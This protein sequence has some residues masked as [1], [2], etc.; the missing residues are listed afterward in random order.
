M[1]S[2]CFRSHGACNDNGRI[3]I[4]RTE[5]RPAGCGVLTAAL[6]GNYS[7]ILTYVADGVSIVSSG[8]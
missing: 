3:S 5:A 2:R 6:P 7:F 4:A 8:D 1:L